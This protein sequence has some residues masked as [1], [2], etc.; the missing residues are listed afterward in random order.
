[1]K[2]TSLATLP[3]GE[4]EIF[5]TTSQASPNALDLKEIILVI[6]NNRDH[7]VNESLPPGFSLPDPPNFRVVVE[8]VLLKCNEN[9]FLINKTE[10]WS[11]EKEL[12]RLH[13]LDPTLPQNFVEFHPTSPNATLQLIV[14]GKSYSGIGI[15]LKDDN[16]SIK[17][18]EVL[19][20]SPAEKAGMKVDDIITH[21]NGE[22][23]S[24]LK[25][26]QVSERIR[27][28]ANSRIN[29]TIQRKGRDEAFELAIDREMI[30]RRPLQQ[31]SA[32]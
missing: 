30:Q 9:K 27:G 3:S 6:R 16:G 5:F 29:L 10:Y 17:V 24:G 18:S 31:G 4:G 7:S 23:V 26:E 21:V 13:T 22:A 25:S 8:R 20:G 15:M 28:P 2:F 14:C 12:I 19:D 11:A 32:K 1:M